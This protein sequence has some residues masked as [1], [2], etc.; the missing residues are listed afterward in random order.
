MDKELNHD[1]NTDPLLDIQDCGIGS[2]SNPEE[3]KSTEEISSSEELI[4]LNLS[5]KRFYILLHNLARLPLSRLGMMVRCRSEKDILQYCEKYTSGTIPEYYFDRTWKGFND[6]LDCYRLGQLHLNSGGM[7]PD[8]L[9]KDLEYWKISEFLLDPCCTIRY[10]PGITKVQQEIES[11]NLCQQKYE[12]RLREEDF[13]D[14]KYGVLRK[15]LWNLTEYPETSRAAQIFAFLSLSVVILSTVTFV[16]ST[17]PQLAPEVDLKLFEETYLDNGTVISEKIERWEEGILVLNVL[18]E[19]IMWFFTIEYLV[20]FICSPNKLKFVTAPLNVVDL[21][22]ILPYFVSRIV[23]MDQLQDTVLMGRAGKVLRLVRVMRI[24]RVFK[25]VR[26]FTGLQSL[27][28]TLQQAYQELG[29]LMLLLTVTVITISSLIYFA[30]K[31]DRDKS[32]TFMESFWFGL[33]ALTSVGNGEKKPNSN[34]GKFIGCTCAILGVFIL[35][36]PV[37]IVL[38]SFSANY[39]NR[40]WR[41]EVMIK[42]QE[43]QGQVKTRQDGINLSPLRPTKVNGEMN[44]NVA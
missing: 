24:L 30:E 34:I 26:H 27:L 40:L 11:E 44:K 23:R 32:W 4:S 43:R 39:K 7:C 9:R 36:L 35:A 38:N 12:E 20:R 31:E 25:L 16:L 37:P 42:K 17:T 1:G 14:S 41:N 3:L 18:D 33:M 6:I 5:G 22:A 8:R 28:S 21:L 2:S 13:G 15:Y 19:F 10:Y 29:L